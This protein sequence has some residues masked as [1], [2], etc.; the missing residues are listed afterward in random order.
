MIFTVEQSD[1]APADAAF[2]LQ[3]NG[4]YSHDA[5]GLCAALAAAGLT[6]TGIES[7]VLRHESR[8]PVG[9]LLVQA[10]R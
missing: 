10:R 9:G 5:A 4:R 7:V 3:P 1:D 8:R 6:T 2:T